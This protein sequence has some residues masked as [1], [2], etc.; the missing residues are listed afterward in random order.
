MFK[1]CQ[2]NLD[3]SCQLMYLILTLVFLIEKN[4][5]NE[6]GGFMDTADE[7]DADNKRLSI[8]RVVDWG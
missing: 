7:G 4:V 1:I 3:I 5:L 6:V 8:G 2:K